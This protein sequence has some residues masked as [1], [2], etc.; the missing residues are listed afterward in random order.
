MTDAARE[1]RVILASVVGEGTVA[2]LADDDQFF[3]RGMIDSLQLVEIIER[4]QVGLGIEV[5]G[6]D[7]SPENF[8]SI[9]GM[10][11]FLERKRASGDAKPI[12]P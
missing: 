2:S 5:A 7:L 6:E 11:T 10:A 3:S 1:V 8:G 9:S 4:F 12:S